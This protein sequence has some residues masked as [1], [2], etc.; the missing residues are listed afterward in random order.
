MT[1]QPITPA[2][3]DDDTI[4]VLPAPPRPAR[5]LW[6]WL[7]LAPL[8]LLGGPAVWLALRPLP[9]PVP[10]PSEL[11]QTPRTVTPTTAA[12]R[13]PEIVPADEATILAAHAPTLQVFRFAEMPKVLVLSFPTLHDQARMLNRIGAFVEKAGMPHDRVVD[14]DEFGG[15][16]RRT[17]ETED[18]YYYGHDY[19]VADLARFFAAAARDGRALHPEEARLQAL[20]EAEGMLAPGVDAAIISIPPES[21]APPIDG[22]ARATI[23]H[24]E[25]SHGLY[26]TDPAYAGYVRSFWLTVPSEAQRAGFRRF[27]GGEGY[28]TA[29]ED[30]MMNEAIAYLVHTPD[31]RYFRPGLAGLSDEAAAALRRSFA[32]GMPESWLRQATLARDP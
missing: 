15:A 1:G 3:Q 10:A 19:R 24:H 26:F 7:G 21:A 5:R 12:A 11:P 27:L 23:L 6:P 4:R 28:D 30:L 29:D 17:G 13:L 8:L 32:R 25:L 2:P 22:A 31:P 18:A 9:G 16:I 20:L 14:D